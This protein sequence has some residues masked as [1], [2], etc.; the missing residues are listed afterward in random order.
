MRNLR[1]LLV[2]LA[3]LASAG[4]AG[5]APALKQDVA[6]ANDVV[7]IGD[8]VSDAGD[9]GDIAVFRAPDLGHVG[10]VPTRQVLDALRQHGLDDIET[11]GIHQVKVTRLS[12][13]FTPEEIEHR[14][15]A[16]LAGQRG[17]GEA[18][19]LT[20]TFDRE[21]RAIEAD[22][23]ADDLHIASLG[24]DPRSRRFD[25]TIV[26]GANGASPLRLRHTGMVVE[27]TPTAV[28]VRPVARGDVIRA[29]DVVVERR[30]RASVSSGALSQPEQLV[31]LAARRALTAAQPIRAADLMKPE[32][33]RQNETVTV[34]YETAGLTLSV[35]G[36]ALES[37]AEGDTVNVLNIQSKRTMQGTVVGLGRV[38]V[39]LMTP[40]ILV[41]APHAGRPAIAAAASTTV[42]E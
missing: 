25:V 20:L 10:T 2:A 28:L 22:V 17:L 31:G 12:R 3:A 19:N 30:P 23:S 21:L 18:E 26:T 27:T 16:T 33:V 13:R 14:I 11:R 24:F 39:K 32:L 5:A 1:L 9:L 6:I 41:N 35:R 7:R 38:S 34:Y 42:I 8:L 15:T 40:Q 4:A 36:K 29:S 37:G